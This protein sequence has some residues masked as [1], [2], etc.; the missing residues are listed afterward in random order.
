VTESLRSALSAYGW[1]PQI[2]DQ[3]EPLADGLVAAPLI[4]VDRGG[5]LAATALGVERCHPPSQ[6]RATGPSVTGDWIT[7]RRQP[8]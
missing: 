5:Y 2:R 8:G 4:R 1:T 6:E 3:F 7:A